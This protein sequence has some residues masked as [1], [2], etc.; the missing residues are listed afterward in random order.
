MT[1][2]LHVGVVLAL[3]WALVFSYNAAAQDAPLFP[4]GTEY[5]L[6]AEVDHT[7]PFVGEQ[8]VYTVRFYAATTPQYIQA[9]PDFQNFWLSDEAFNLSAEIINGRQYLIHTTAILLYPLQAGEQTIDPTVIT[10]PQT[11]FTDAD[12]LISNPVTVNVQPL[13]SDGQ[14]AGFAGA[15]GTFEIENSVDRPTVTLSEPVL[16]RLRVSGSGN[17]EL[18]ARPELTTPHGWRA[19]PR[20]T[21]TAISQRG[22]RRFGVRVFEWRLIPDRAGTAQVGQFSFSYFDPLRLDYVTLTLDPLTVDVLPGAGNVF[23]SVRID[24]SA[25]EN[26]QLPLLTV[27]PASPDRLPVPAGVLGW[28]APPLAC[29]ALWGVLRL[30]RWQ[31]H[32]TS[33]RRIANALGRALRSLQVARTLEPPRAF[34]A[35]EAVVL[36]YL[37]DKLDQPIDRQS[38]IDHP[39][40]PPSVQSA[41]TACLSAAETGRYTPQSLARQLVAPLVADTAQVLKEIDTLW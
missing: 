21:D 11:L 4:A 12:Q 13:P 17:L 39:R 15:V 34:L 24:R 28:I 33:Q 22:N 10:I 6:T 29:L 41:V 9:L 14:P 38:L 30:R 19:Y 32:R 27:S 23:E 35:V 7:T 40:I 18:L 5:F 37:S 1:G 8:V 16:L 2:R 3:A 31:A 36:A 26:R 25:F 20:T